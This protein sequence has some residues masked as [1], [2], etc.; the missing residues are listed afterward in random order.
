VTEPHDEPDTDA[1]VGGRPDAR[2]EARTDEGTGV[3]RLGYV[4][5]ATPA[6]WVRTWTERRPDRPLELVPVTPDEAGDFVRAGAVDVAILRLP[7]DRAGLHAISLY[8]EVAVVVVSRDH[9]I[10]ALEPDEHADV[11]DLADDV[12]LEPAD[13]VL[14]WPGG[15]TPGRRPV[16]QPTTTGLA[17]ELVAAGIGVLVVPQSLARLHH[18]KDVTYRVLDGAPPAPVALAWAVDAPDDEVAA[19][20]EDFVGIVR[21]RTANSSRGRAPAADPEPAP[22]RGASPP[23][24]G[25]AG[26]PGRGAASGGRTSGGRAPGGGRSGGGRSGGSRRR[27]SGR[28]R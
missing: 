8:D 20:V 16:E 12:F 3:F 5:G 27:G 1:R 2:T 28:G 13:D 11:A 26:A 21:G 25:G 17:V 14:D 6:K 15:V 10:A 22:P 23:A 4:P 24:R 9:V 7:T 19:D 18:R